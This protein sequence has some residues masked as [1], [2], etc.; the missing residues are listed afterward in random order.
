MDYKSLH[1]V[2]IK[3]HPNFMPKFASDYGSTMYIDVMKRLYI[4]PRVTNECA[5]MFFDSDRKWFDSS[6]SI[7]KEMV[8]QDR[9]GQ[10]SQKLFITIG[11]N[12]QTWSIPECVKVIE[13]IKQ[14]DWIKGLKA[15]FELHRTNG[16]HPHVHFLIELNE[17][18]P[19]SKVLE[20]LWATKGIKKI[21]L[22]K[23]FIDYKLAQ[24]YH[25][26]YIM[27]DK[28]DEKMDCVNK[29]IKWRSENN[30]PE[31]FEK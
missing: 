1:I 31:L 16:E 21:C 20:K 14:Y 4:N 28:C 19:K 9:K 8:K 26:A 11:F 17:Q 24:D 30:I 25:N 12:H 22:A 7:I 23:S 13:K 3:S 15:R 18:I 29:D 6:N 2:W 10:D 5:K 27:L